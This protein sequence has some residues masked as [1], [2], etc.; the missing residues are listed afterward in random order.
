MLTRRGVLTTA[1]LLALTPL[2]AEDSKPAAKPVPGQVVELFDGKTLTNWKAAEFG[3]EGKVTVEDG[4]LV[5]GAGEPIT[6]ATWS[7]GELPKVD[8]EITFEAQRAAGSDFFATLTF[9]VQKDTCSLVIGGWG[10]GVTGL[11]S[12]DGYDASENGTTNY[13]EYKAGQW[14]KVR[15]RVT[16][17]HITAWIDQEQVLDVD[18]TD[19]KVGIRIEVEL[20]KPLGFT[21]FRTKGLIR[22][23]KLEHLAP[24][25]APKKSE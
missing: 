22:K 6:G 24:S 11:S 8:Y 1:C 14:Y 17:S 25:E 18:Y 10:G 13:L 12:L 20:S 15:L 2:L 16:K 23:L 9:P 4:C 5:I 7:G 19:K 21:T 3:G